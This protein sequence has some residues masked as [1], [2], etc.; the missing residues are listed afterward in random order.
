MEVAFLF[1]LEC[2]AVRGYG[3]PCWMGNSEGR[4]PPPEFPDASV[5]YGSALILYAEG[6]CVFYGVVF[7]LHELLLR[8]DFFAPDISC[9][10][11][12]CLRAPMAQGSLYILGQKRLP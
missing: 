9:Y 7:I 10:I 11:L 1:F 8:S 2:R 6:T 5:F 4:N 3:V 12:R